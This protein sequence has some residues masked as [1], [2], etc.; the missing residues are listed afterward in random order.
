MEIFLS[1]PDTLSDIKVEEHFDVFKITEEDQMAFRLEPLPD[2]NIGNHAIHIHIVGD[3]LVYI[4]DM[5]F[6]TPGNL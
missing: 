3:W 2:I 4:N 6:N 5:D 1:L